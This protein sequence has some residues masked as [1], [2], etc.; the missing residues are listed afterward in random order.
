MADR[1]EW[2]LLLGLCSVPSGQ[3][4]PAPLDLQFPARY[5]SRETLCTRRTPGQAPSGQVTPPRWTSGFLPVMFH[6]KRLCSRRTLGPG[7]ECTKCGSV[8]PN[9]PDVR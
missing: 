5:V 9:E 1:I 8:A 3:V 6:V 2:G 4:A 7:A